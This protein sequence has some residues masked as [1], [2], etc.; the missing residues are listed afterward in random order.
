MEIRHP[1]RLTIQAKKQY[2]VTEMPLKIFGDRGPG[3]LDG[4]KKSQ[5]SQPA[6]QTKGSTPS[7]RVDFSSILQEVCRA[8]ETSP[9]ADIQR[10]EKV[11]A[12]KEQITQGNYHPDLH[13]VATSLL[14]FLVQGK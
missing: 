1:W 7:D 4:V 6:K 13:K 10:S 14:R 2:Q 8:K 11:R 12:L 9:A 5:K 3:P